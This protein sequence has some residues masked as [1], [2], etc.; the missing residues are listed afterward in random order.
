[1]SSSI[2]LVTGGLGFIGKHFVQR[3]L[4]AGHVVINVDQQNY[5]SDI[6]IGKTFDKSKNYNFIKE[7]IAT[8]PYLPECDFIINFAAESHVDNSISSSLQFCHS[9]FLGVQRLLDLVKAKSALERPVFLQ[10][11]TD[12]VYGD[13]KMAFTAK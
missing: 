6:S 11:S 5:A 8:L 10:I 9:N 4:K 3:V 7:D 13:L 2:F 12:E 1:M